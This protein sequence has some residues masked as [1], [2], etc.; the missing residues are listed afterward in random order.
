VFSTSRELVFLVE[1]GACFYCLCFRGSMVFAI[2]K[3]CVLVAALLSFEIG[4]CH[5][6]ALI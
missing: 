3:D 1:F 5:P 2:E 4:I 6:Y